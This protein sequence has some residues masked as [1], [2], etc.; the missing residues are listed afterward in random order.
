MTLS[1]PAA[2][3]FVVVVV[4]KYDTVI[5]DQSL[6]IRD[7]FCGFINIIQDGFGFVSIRLNLSSKENLFLLLL[8]PFQRNLN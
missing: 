6:V 5:T 3:F 1:I 2:E 4:I 7:W 8:F